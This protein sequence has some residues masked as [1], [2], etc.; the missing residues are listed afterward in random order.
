[1]YLTLSQVSCIHLSLQNKKEILKAQEKAH[2]RLYSYAY[3]L[4]DKKYGLVS[5]KVGW[6]VR[7]KSNVTKFPNR[8]K[9]GR[10]GGNL[11]AVA[12]TWSPKAMINVQDL[13]KT[14]QT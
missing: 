1:M 12:E 9:L 4:S 8:D 14:Y 2:L 7:E 6:S 3:W 11:V 13:L 5:L 10:Y